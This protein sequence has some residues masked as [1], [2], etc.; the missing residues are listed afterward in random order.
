MDI[1]VIQPNLMLILVLSVGLRRAG[2][3]D[4]SKL[5][6]TEMMQVEICCPLYSDYIRWIINNY[7]LFEQLGPGLKCCK[8]TA[9]CSS[10]D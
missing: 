4:I 3:H 9:E 10:H 7:S 1:K 2:G 6:T 8:Q 5:R